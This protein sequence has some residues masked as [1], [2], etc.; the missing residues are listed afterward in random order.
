[1]KDPLLLERLFCCL[2][3]VVYCLKDRELR[4]L[5]ANDAFAERVHL[6]SRWEVVGKRAGDFFPEVLAAHYHAQDEHILATGKGFRER[7]EL[8]PLRNRELGWFLSSK[9]PVFNRADELVGIACVSCDLRLPSGQEKGYREMAKV[10]EEMEE[11][12]SE[13]LSRAD[14]AAKAGLSEL[15]FERRLK[16]IFGLS[17]SALLRK[18][19]I[20]HGSRLLVESDRSLL[21][22][23]HACGYSEQSS[24]ARQFK[25]A[26]GLS[27]GRYR[28]DYRDWW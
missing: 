6:G 10:V 22:I 5:S 1:M 20:D 12:F 27:P 15:Q 14:F 4:Y 21:E 17:F 8:L 11:R 26:V 7:L 24:F 16:R 25:S 3:D 23:A 2:P 13:S 28:E 9:E 18:L 19:R